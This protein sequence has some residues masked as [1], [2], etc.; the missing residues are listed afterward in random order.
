M[1]TSSSFHFL[2]ISFFFSKILVI[3][4][5]NLNFLFSDYKR[6]KKLSK[7]IKDYHQFFFAYI[8]TRNPNFTTKFMYESS[9]K[10]LRTT[11]KT[12]FYTTTNESKINYENHPF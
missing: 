12:S 9:L 11:H 3:I 6:K 4:K 10:F 8:C 7:K 2:D 1:L 5:R